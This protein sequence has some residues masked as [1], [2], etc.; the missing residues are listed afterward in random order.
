MNSTSTASIFATAS[1][2]ENR[3]PA[4]SRCFDRCQQ[5]LSGGDYRETLDALLEW[6][7]RVMNN[8]GGA[9]WVHIGEDGRLDVRYRGTE[10]ALP[11]EDEL[12]ELWRNGYFIDSLKA[13]TRQL[14]NAP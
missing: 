4:A 1:T 11:S 14:A 2:S 5:G 10:R 13:I 12:P 3:N 8:R 9:S 6:H 7:K